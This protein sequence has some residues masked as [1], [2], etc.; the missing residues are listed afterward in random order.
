MSRNAAQL[1]A[2]ATATGTYEG[3]NGDGAS[4]PW[5]VA[6]PANLPL[7]FTM[8]AY[9]AY[10]DFRWPHAFRLHDWCYTPYGALIN[11]TRA[12]ADNALYELIAV[13]SSIDALIVYTA[14]NFGGEPWFGHGWAGYAGIQA[15]LPV[16][17]MGSAHRN[18]KCRVC[19]G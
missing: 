8:F 6:L 16:P 2:E 3:Y 18:C 12:E 11:C 14:V 15:E 5:Q 9:K 7:G 17:N 4:V 13:D 1:I 10:L 19:Q